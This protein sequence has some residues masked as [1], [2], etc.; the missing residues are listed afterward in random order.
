MILRRKNHLPSLKPFLFG[1]NALENTNNC[2]YLGLRVE[3]TGSTS[4]TITDRIEKSRRAANMCH[5]ALITTGTVSVQIALKLF[6]TQISP[7]LTYSCPVYQ[8]SKLPLTKS[9]C[10]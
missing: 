5:Q 7:I 6:D 1:S 10:M 3:A 2:Q 8:I 9:P 4:A